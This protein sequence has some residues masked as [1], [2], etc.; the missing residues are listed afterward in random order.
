VT[1]QFVFGL[2]ERRKPNGRDHQQGREGGADG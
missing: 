2:P 1:Y